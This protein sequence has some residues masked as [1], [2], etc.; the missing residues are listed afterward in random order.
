[1][2]AV[3]VTRTFKVSL[4]VKVV[5]RDHVLV[6]IVLVAVVQLLPLLID[7]STISP[8]TLTALKVPLMV[9]AAVL[10]MKSVEL[11][12]VSAEKVFVAIVVVGA[13]VSST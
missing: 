3:S 4:A 5:A 10:V 2:P 1:M 11:I 9:C 7:T 12:P 6:P 13:V 8:V